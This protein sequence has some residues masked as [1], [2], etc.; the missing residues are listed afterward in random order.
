MG[1]TVAIDGDRDRVVYDGPVA[2]Q[3]VT[4]GF[5]D[6]VVRAQPTPVASTV[7]GVPSPP[8]VLVLTPASPSF[9]VDC[10]NRDVLVR[11]DS[12]HYVLRGGCRSL[13]VQGRLDLITA[14]L[15]PGAPVTV[16]GPGVIL[17]YVLIAQG[18]APVV[19]VT[20][21]SLRAEQIQHYGDSQL[22]LPT[23][24]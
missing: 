14:E 24:R 11:G 21:P 19:R 12:Q 17:N 4:H 6:Q 13:T 3:A 15:V 1:G 16:G 23:Y 7:E 8:P 9:D 20:S 10:T 18:P 5:Y 2:P 22:S